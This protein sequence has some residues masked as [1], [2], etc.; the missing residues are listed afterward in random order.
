MSTLEGCN[1]VNVLSRLQLSNCS[2]GFRRGKVLRGKRLTTPIAICLRKL[3]LVCFSQSVV[4]SP[5]DLQVWMVA[6]RCRS[7]T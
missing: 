4:T 5:L 1:F 7:C 2:G 3:H 6:R